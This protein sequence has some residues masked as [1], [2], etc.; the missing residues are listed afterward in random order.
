MMPV[1]VSQLINCS[2]TDFIKSK[3]FFELQYHQIYSVVLWHFRAHQSKDTLTSNALYNLR[4][5]IVLALHG[6]SDC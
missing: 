1:V 4:L 3:I 6:H 5:L 2:F